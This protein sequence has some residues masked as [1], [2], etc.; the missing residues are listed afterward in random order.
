MSAVVT[1]DMLEG[2]LLICYEGGL[3]KPT[4]QELMQLVGDDG[5]GAIYPVSQVVC[6]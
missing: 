4:Y 3:E 6:D 1:R 5:R 2:L